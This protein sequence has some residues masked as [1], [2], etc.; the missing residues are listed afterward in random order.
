MFITKKII[1]FIYYVWFG[2]KQLFCIDSKFTLD[3]IPDPEAK[4][5]FYNHSKL[6]FLPPTLPGSKANL[7]F[8]INKIIFHPLFNSEAKLSFCINS[9]IISFIHGT[10]FRSK[11]VLCAQNF[12]DNV[13]YSGIQKDFLYLLI[14]PSISSAERTSLIPAS[15]NIL[16]SKDWSIGQIH[17]KK[18]NGK[19]DLSEWEGKSPEYH[20]DISSRA[21]LS[22]IPLIRPKCSLYLD[23]GLGPAT[24]WAP[25]PVPAPPKMPKLG[26][27]PAPSPVQAPSHC[28]ILGDIAGIAWPDIMSSTRKALHMI[29]EAPPSKNWVSITGSPRRSM[30]VSM[31]ALTGCQGVVG[32]ANPPHRTG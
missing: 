13:I 31:P 20:T 8:C 11:V 26:P 12:S 32:R 22:T 28:Q 18:S 24:N 21:S 17:P 5:S 25:N 2:R 23:L 29:P 19:F 16:A 4:L 9:K 27:S 6:I 7:S 3:L 14:S 15:N 30:S 10:W 1:L